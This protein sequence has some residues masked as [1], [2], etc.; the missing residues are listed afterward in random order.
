MGFLL[1]HYGIRHLMREAA[2]QADRGTDRRQQGPT[3]LLGPVAMLR[4]LG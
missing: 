3:F 4:M 2:D 1:T